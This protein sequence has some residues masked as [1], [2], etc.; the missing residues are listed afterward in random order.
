MKGYTAIAALA[1]ISS[2]FAAPSLTQVEAPSQ[3]KLVARQSSAITPITVKGNGM[4]F[5]SPVGA[6]C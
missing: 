3:P 5:N 1:A 2:T 6:N 4:P